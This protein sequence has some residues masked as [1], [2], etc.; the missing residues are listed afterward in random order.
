MFLRVHNV[1]NRLGTYLFNIWG[2]TEGGTLTPGSGLFVGPTGIACTHH[3]NPPRGSE[4]QYIDG[5]Y[6]IEIFVL[7][8]QPKPMKL[9]EVAFGLDD[10]S[11]AQLLQVEHIHLDLTWN[12][13]ERGYDQNSEQ[14]PKASIRQHG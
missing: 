5:A 3:F 9:M 10:W 11:A 14:R 4:F 6:R 7:V 2:H 1:H 12:A 8:D 13:D